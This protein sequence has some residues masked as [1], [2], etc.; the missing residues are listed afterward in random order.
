MPKLVKKQQSE[1]KDFLPNLLRMG[2][3]AADFK[4]SK[5]RA[6]DV[7]ELTLISDCFLI[8]SVSSEPQLKA[9]Y[10]GIR[11]RMKEETGL[12][13]L[14]TEGEFS[15]N[16]VILDYGAMLVHIFREKARELYDLDGLWGD[17]PEINLE[18]NT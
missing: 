17:A 11:E 18:L 5:I 15:S 16:W 14:N 9:V 3:I 13:P 2:S 10:N 4:A 1:E 6:L 12:K 8:C 7:R